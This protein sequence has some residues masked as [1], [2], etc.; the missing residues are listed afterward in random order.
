MEKGLR[1]HC[2]EY[3]ENTSLDWLLLRIQFEVQCS[4]LPSSTHFASSWE[5]ELPEAALEVAKNS[6]CPPRTPVPGSMLWQMNDAQRQLCAATFW[7][8]L[9][10]LFEFWISCELEAYGID[11][12]FFSQI[13]TWTTNLVNFNRDF[14]LVNNLHWQDLTWPAFIWAS[15]TRLGV[16]VG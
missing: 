5:L 4:I 6:L 14:T 1:I 11:N 7:S 8:D 16:P 3:R 10:I 2:E 12:I 13:P 15:M 9:F